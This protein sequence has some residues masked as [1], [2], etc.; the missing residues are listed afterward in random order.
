VIKAVL[1]DWFNT[2]VHYDP[3][4]EELYRKVFQES[5][6]T[7]SFREIY[8]GLLVGDRYFFSAQARNL[9]RG[10]GF[11]ERAA[12]FTLYCRAIA[13]E[14][15]L[16]I[17]PE[18]QLDI[19]RK[20]LKQFTGDYTLYEDVL[21]VFQWLKQK[22]MITG[23]ITN[24]DKNVAGLI[25]KLGAKPF[26]DVLVT[27]GEVGVDKPAPQIF[28]TALERA[29]VKNQEAIYIG[30]QYQSDVL[31]AGGVGMKA[32]LLDRYDINQETLAYPLIKSLEEIREYVLTAE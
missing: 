26:M 20:V 27:S 10:A 8:K 22:G 1:F 9:V 23:V 15:G 18:L 32:L 12:Q 25:E 28:L 13:A 29:K 31:G 4:R 17:T 30:D 2:L 11:E 3:P 5:G 19:I 6:I 21:P 7:V 14:A 16:E 24:A